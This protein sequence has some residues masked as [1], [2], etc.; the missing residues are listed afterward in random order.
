MKHMV[1]NR[2]ILPMMNGEGETKFAIIVYGRKPDELM[3]M[4]NEVIHKLARKYP[5][6]TTSPFLLSSPEPIW[7]RGSNKLKEGKRRTK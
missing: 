2:T 1:K 6:H 4:P 7:G 5:N 3:T